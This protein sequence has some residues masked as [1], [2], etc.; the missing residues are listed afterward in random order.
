MATGHFY[1]ILWVKANHM[2]ESRVKGWENMLHLFLG[3][4]TVTC[5]EYEDKLGKIIVVTNVTDRP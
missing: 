3:R 1:T 5:K 2:A 4:T